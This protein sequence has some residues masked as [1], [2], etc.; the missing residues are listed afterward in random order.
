MIIWEKIMG[1]DGTINVV[2]EEELPR[3]HLGCYD[4]HRKGVNCYATDSVTKTLIR[5]TG[6][7]LAVS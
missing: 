1:Y 5:V 2:A 4:K 6:T 7:L 3:H